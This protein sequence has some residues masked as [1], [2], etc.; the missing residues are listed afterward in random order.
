MD[1]ISKSIEDRHLQIQNNISDSFKKGPEDSITSESQR[2]SASQFIGTLMSVQQSAAITHRY[3]VD[4]KLSTHEALGDF[5]TELDPMIDELI[6]TYQGYKKEQ[7]DL[8]V[9]AKTML[10]PKDSIQQ[11]YDFI[12]SNRNFCNESFI[13]NQIDNIVSLIAK[14]LFKLEFVQ[15]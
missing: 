6:E 8:Q 15:S 2:T 4:K 14:T 5:Y 3:Q 10:N 11:L 1:E 13:Q 9:F 7:V 12:A